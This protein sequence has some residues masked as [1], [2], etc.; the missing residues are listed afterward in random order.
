MLIIND[1]INI[2]IINLYGIKLSGSIIKFNVSIP[3]NHPF[4]ELKIS[5]YNR[6]YYSKNTREYFKQQVGSVLV[7][8]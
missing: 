7:L 3:L 2:A 4:F 8:I 6:T 1:N 5:V